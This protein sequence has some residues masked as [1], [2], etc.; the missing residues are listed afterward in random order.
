M[1]YGCGDGVTCDVVEEVGVII[2]YMKFC[3]E[4]PLKWM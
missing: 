4:E 1:H 3:I 2:L